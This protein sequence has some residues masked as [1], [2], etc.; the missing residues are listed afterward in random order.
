MLVNGPL[1]AEAKKWADILNADASAIVDIDEPSR[2]KFIH[3][4]TNDVKKSLATLSRLGCDIAAAI[5]YKNWNNEVSF[6][7][8]KVLEN[9]LRREKITLAKQLRLHHHLAKTSEKM[10]GRYTLIERQKPATV[11]ERRRK[12]REDL[13]SIFELRFGRESGHSWITIP[14]EKILNWPE[15]LSRQVSSWGIQE[16]DKL[17]HAMNDIDFV[18]D[19]NSTNGSND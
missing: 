5:Q 17:K 6:N 9:C 7:A 16:L 14:L 19:L 10:K 2:I 11:N 12:A 15:N 13:R 18:N 3:G 1:F 4:L 8:G